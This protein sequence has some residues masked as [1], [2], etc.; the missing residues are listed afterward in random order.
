MVD[1]AEADVV[2]VLTRAPSTGGKSRL[3]ETLRCAPDPTLIT[4][5]LLDTLG[6]VASSGCRR[7][8][9][10]EPASAC[11]EVG[12]LLGGDVDVVPQREGS[13]GDRMRGLFE[14]LLRAGARRVVLI[15]SD[16]PAISAQPVAAAFAALRRDPDAIVLGPAQDGGYYLIAASH[17]PDVFDGIAWGSSR[18]LDQTREA[19]ARAARRLVLVD[20]CSDIDTAADLQR[21]LTTSD[22]RASH[23]TAWARTHA[24][25]LKGILP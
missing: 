22:G 17:V 20:P 1:A 10:V 12:S 7:V 25:A 3:F 24:E 14:D 23:T 6:G 9:A 19:A 4:A 2:A 21:L 8:V 16:L 18:V 15:G 5:L 11:A 13:L